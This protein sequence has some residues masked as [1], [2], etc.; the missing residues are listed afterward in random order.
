MKKWFQILDNS[1]GLLSLKEVITKSKAS[2]KITLPHCLEA[3]YRQ[4]KGRSPN[5]AQFSCRIAEIGDRSLGRPRQ[6][7]CVGQSS[8]MEE[9]AQ[10][11]Y[12]PCPSY[13]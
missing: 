6:L 10:T 9:T 12:T 4:Q 3:V 11:A 13:V 1:I 5:R 8:R 2:P 7:Q